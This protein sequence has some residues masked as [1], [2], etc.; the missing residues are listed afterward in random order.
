MVL[1]RSTSGV[2]MTANIASFDPAKGCASESR[3]FS[4]QRRLRS[5]ATVFAVSFLLLLTGMSVRPSMYDEGIT[6]TGA[7]RV[8]GGQLPHRDFYTN[9]GPAHFYILAGL[10]KLFGESLLVE[11]L[12][13]ASICALI[14]ASVFWISSTY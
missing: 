4:A 1:N 13:Y 11:R 7:M 12:L 5:A 14:V 3:S 9:Y 8:L 6:V 2:W 10:F